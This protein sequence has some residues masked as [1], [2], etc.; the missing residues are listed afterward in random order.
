VRHPQSPAASVELDGDGVEDDWNDVAC[1]VGT[2]PSEA[3]H[4]NAGAL[5]PTGIRPWRPRQRNWEST[6]IVALIRTKADKHAALC[7]VIDPRTR[8]EFAAVKWT[9]I[10]S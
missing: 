10:A 1:Y 7:N 2:T 9:R 4:A 6:E 3:S 8:M 5:T